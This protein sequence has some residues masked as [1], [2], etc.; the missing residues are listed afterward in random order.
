MYQNGS[1]AHRRNFQERRILSLWPAQCRAACGSRFHPIPFFRNNAYGMHQ[2]YHIINEMGIMKRITT[3][4]A[5]LLLLSACSNSKSSSGEP[6]IEYYRPFHEVVQAFAQLDANLLEYSRN[7][8]TEKAALLKA[9]GDL[10]ADNEEVTAVR[11]LDSTYIYIT[12]ASGLEVVYSLMATDADGNPLTRG[13]GPGSGGSTLV[14]AG[15]NC[16]NDIENRKVLI[17]NAQFETSSEA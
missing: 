2:E 12:L 5:S 7:G 11:D 13:A 15:G 17:Y 9:A 1:R 6:D 8:E 14:R 4:L 16:A 3:I 10:L